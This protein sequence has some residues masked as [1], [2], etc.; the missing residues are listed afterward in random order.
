VADLFD[1]ISRAMP[2][3]KPGTL[4]RNEYADIVAYLLESNKHPAGQTELPPDSALLK[5]YLIDRSAPTR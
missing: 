4:S 2:A 5:T 3:D 1:K